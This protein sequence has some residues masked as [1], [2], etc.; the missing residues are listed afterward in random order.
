LA[1]ASAPSRRTYSRDTAGLLN[2]QSGASPRARLC[3]SS[4]GWSPGG[5][6]TWVARCFIACESW[7]KMY[8]CRA[9]SRPGATPASV[10]L[11][12][13]RALGGSAL[14]V[15]RRAFRP[16]RCCNLMRSTPTESHRVATSSRTTRSTGLRRRGHFKL[17]S[18]ERCSLIAGSIRTR[19]WN[20]RW[21]QFWPR[22]IATSNLR[23][24]T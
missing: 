23:T 15:R 8:R 1:A 20:A 22:L 19:G 14:H 17:T 3:H 9:C 6:S 12:Y 5:K 7:S 2:E 18:P 4:P 10:V 11:G 13:R 21:E 16:S 24:S